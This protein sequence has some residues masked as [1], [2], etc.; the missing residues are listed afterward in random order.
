MFEA[1][2]FVD[3]GFKAKEFDS[4]DITIVYLFVCILGEG[5]NLT[6]DGVLHTIYWEGSV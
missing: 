6:P 4:M 1:Y 5:D 3:F 2:Y